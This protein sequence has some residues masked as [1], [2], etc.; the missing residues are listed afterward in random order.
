GL[1]HLGK[2]ALGGELAWHSG[3]RWVAGGVL[4]VAAVYEVTPMKN[5]CLVKCRTPVG[6]LVGSW[7]DGWRGALEMGSRHA[8]W[9]LG[10]CWALM[11][12][13]FALGVMSLS[14]M[15]LVAALI[16]I[17]KTIPWRRAVTWGTGAILLALAVGV[18]AAP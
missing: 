18:V 3:G 17:E 11:A 13:L 2:S 14:W 1:F 8:A 16:A 10:C 4:A 15:A 7:R 6:F 9:C 5:V 12:A